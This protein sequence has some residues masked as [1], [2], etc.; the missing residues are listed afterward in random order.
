MHELQVVEFHLSFGHKIS[1]YLPDDEKLH[2]YTWFLVPFY[3][4]PRSRNVML[5]VQF[6]TSAASVLQGQR[7]H[8]SI[9]ARMDRIHQ[10]DLLRRCLRLSTR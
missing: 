6:A 9:R 5:R 3:V 4:D 1:L 7:S 10:K 2:V 8:A